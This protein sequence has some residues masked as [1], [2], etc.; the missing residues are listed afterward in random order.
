MTIET[1]ISPDELAALALVVERLHG[2]RVDVAELEHDLAADPD[3]RFFLARYEGQVVGS[4]VGKRSSLQGTLYA[5]ARVLAEARRQGAG[6]ALYEALS[7]HAQSLGLQQL[8]GRVFDAEALQFAL[9]RGLEEFGREI[10]SVL[11][12]TSTRAAIPPPPGVD[13]TSFGDRPDLAP[14]AHAIDAEAVPDIPTWAE[15]AAGPYETWRATNLE[16][17]SALPHACMVALAGGEVIGYA[18][19]LART[20]EP[21]T[22]E[23]QLT[24]VRRAW[25]GR[26][27]ANRSQERPDRLGG[28]ERLRPTRHLQRRG[29]R[30]DARDQRQAGLRAAA[31]GRA[32][33]R[34]AR[35]LGSR[36]MSLR[37]PSVDHGI[38]SFVWAF[39]LG[40]LLWAFMLGIGISKATSFIV[41]ALVAC[42]IFLYVRLYGEDDPRRRSGS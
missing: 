7:A 42:G 6:A 2:Q 34:P 24:A 18:A 12:I 19:L 16:G 32:R 33:P 28:G 27:V 25:R 35:P 41:A 17:P 4:G 3:T 26:G 9:S 1:A 13:I 10:E 23:H 37:P 30:G 14:A 8:W 29:K 38:M 5:I 31:A 22:A 15:L 20:A 21:G 36:A 11:T 40:V 39:L